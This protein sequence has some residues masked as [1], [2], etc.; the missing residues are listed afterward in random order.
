MFS[1]VAQTTGEQVNANKT[2]WHLIGFKWDATGKWC[3]ANNK[4]DLFLNTPKGPQKLE[5]PP[6]YQS[7]RIL[8]VCI[9]PDGSPTKEMKQRRLITSS[10]EDKVSSG[11]IK[12]SDTWY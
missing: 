1:G 2:K 5:R 6:P 12:K 11:H 4:E 10:W 9:S 7:S 8:G 3:L